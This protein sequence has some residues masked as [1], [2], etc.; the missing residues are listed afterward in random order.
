MEFLENR[1][2][3]EN[4]KPPRKSPEKWRLL[5]LAVYNAPSL[6]T[7]DFGGSSS[8]TDTQPWTQ[9]SWGGIVMQ[10]G[11]CTSIV[12]RNGRR[13]PMLLLS[14]AAIGRCDSPENKQIPLV[15][16]FRVRGNFK[17]VHWNR[18]TAPKRFYRTLFC[19]PKRFYGTLVRG[20]SEPQTGFYRTFRIETPLFRLPFKILHKSGNTIGN[21][22]CSLSSKRAPNLYYN[23][24]KFP[25][26]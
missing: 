18:A 24:H 13:I 16:I 26:K 11:F 17:T 25:P 23:S 10:M 3:W 2:S 8:Q 22:K 7:V 20:T 4:Q 9:N 1:R 15:P 19:A 6:H 5:S 12:D 14:I 21:E